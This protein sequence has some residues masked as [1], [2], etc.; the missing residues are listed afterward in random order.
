[1]SAVLGWQSSYFINKPAH[2]FGFYNS[3]NC[4]TKLLISFWWNRRIS[5]Q[6]IKGVSDVITMKILIHLFVFIWLKFCLQYWVRIYIFIQYF[7]SKN[8]IYISSIWFKLSTF[9]QYYL[10]LW[11][12]SYITDWL[13]ANHFTP[14]WCYWSGRN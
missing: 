5:K 3:C 14:L 4:I 12:T 10:S 11:P 13:D 1:M 7:S 6:D 2:K 8:S 9:F